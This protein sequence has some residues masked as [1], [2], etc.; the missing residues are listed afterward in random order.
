MFI[1]VM[2]TSVVK[3]NTIV[4][5]IFIIYFA[6]GAAFYI[7]HKFIRPT[8]QRKNMLKVKD[9]IKESDNMWTIN[10]VPQNRH[11]ISYKPGQFGFLKL[12]SKNIKTEEH[13]FSISSSPSNNGYISF[14][15]KE[16]GDYT[17]NIGKLEVGSSACI[18]GPYGKFSY[19]EYP[20]EKYTVLIAGGVGITPMLSMLRYMNDKDNNHNVILLWGV[21]TNNDLICKNEIEAIQKEMRNLHIVP[22][23]AKDNSWQGEKGYINSQ[24]IQKVVK[25]YQYDINESGFYICGPGPMAEVVVK[26][27]KAIGVKRKYIHFEKFSM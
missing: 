21:N 20:N 7:Y 11:I 4:R 24:L 2:A 6:V 14:T 15:I 27:L 23:M 22:V 17:A 1:H 25:Q 16:L 3:Y 8:M 18:D 12:F 13:P 9:V 19:L 10:L 5:W 26:G